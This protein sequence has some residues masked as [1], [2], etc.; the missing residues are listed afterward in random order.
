MTTKQ[1]TKKI[2]TWLP[3]FSGFYGTVWESNDDDEENEI[4]E[5]NHIRKEKNLP[6][7]TFDDC[8]WS[9]N[10][11]HQEVVEK[12]TQEIGERL[13]ENN[14]IQ[15]YEL[16][17]L[18]SPREYNFHNDSI[19]VQFELNETN[20][21]TIMQY[22]QKHVKSFEQYLQDKYTSRS[23]FISSY[24]NDVNG[25]MHEDD[26]SHQHKLGSILQFILENDY[27]TEGLDYP[28]EHEICEDI[29]DYPSVYALNY[30]E[31]TD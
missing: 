27:K 3:V 2:E 19:D 29:P 11:Y 15:G 28:L 10:N 24:D 31:L 17:G 14:Y 16:Q 20:I 6:P 7:I 8:E 18:R 26:L 9:Y 12:V 21:R 4:D 13:K 1:K 5:I 25:W 30:H 23:G 22:L